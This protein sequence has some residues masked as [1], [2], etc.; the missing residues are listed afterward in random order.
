[1]HLSIQ[2]GDILRC[3]HLC[4]HNPDQDIKHFHQVFPHTPNHPE[5]TTTTTMMTSIDIA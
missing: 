1:M 4:S 3:S 2:L 5:T